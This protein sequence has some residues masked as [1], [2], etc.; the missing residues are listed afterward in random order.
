MLGKCESVSES[1]DLE[2]MKRVVQAT[3]P[4]PKIYFA[5]SVVDLAK[6]SKPLGEVESVEI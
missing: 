6:K 4:Q 2:K 5:K 1:D 3:R